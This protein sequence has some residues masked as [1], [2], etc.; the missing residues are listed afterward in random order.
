MGFIDSLGNIENEI[1]YGDE[2][3]HE[4]IHWIEPTSDGVIY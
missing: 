1:I 4:Q 3:K 2:E